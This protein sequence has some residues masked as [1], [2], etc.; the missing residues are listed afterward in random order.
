MAA[1]S[2]DDMQKEIIAGFSD[3][4]SRVRIA[5]AKAL[6]KFLERYRGSRGMPSGITVEYSVSPADFSS[7]PPANSSSDGIFGGVAKIL[8]DIAKN[9]VPAPTA[10]VEIEKEEEMKVE[11]D[12]EEEKRLR[13]TP[14]ENEADPAQDKQYQERGEAPPFVPSDAAPGERKSEA[15]SPFLPAPPAPAHSGYSIR[16]SATPQPVLRGMTR[17]PSFLPPGTISPDQGTAQFDLIGGE[18]AAPSQAAYPAVPS[19][20]GKDQWLEEFYQ[21]KSRPEWMTKTIEPLE[22]MLSAESLE[23][24]MAAAVA[25]VPLGKADLAVPALL[26]GAKAKPEF[27]CAAA[28]ILPWMVREKRAALFSDLRAVAGRDGD[29]ILLLD[30]L[31]EARDSRDEDLFWDVLDGER[32]SIDVA[33][34]VYNSLQEFYSIQRSNH[35]SGYVTFGDTSPD[36]QPNPETAKK[37]S[38]RTESGSDFQ[39]LVALALMCS[40]DREEAAK[41]AARI[42]DDS[43]LGEAL[44]RDAFQISLLLQSDAKARTV[45][46]VD[47]LKQNDPQRS[48]IALKVLVGGAESLRSLRERIDLAVPIPA[49][50]SESVGNGQPIIPRTPRGLKIDDVKPLVKDADPEIAAYAGYL[51]ALFE[52]PSGMPQLLRYWHKK[53]KENAS[54]SRLVYRAVAVLD[55]PKYLPVLRQIYGMTPEP[56]SKDFYWTIRIMSGP[57]ILKFRKEIRDRQ[58]TPGT[59]IMMPERASLSPIP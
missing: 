52:D 40:L 59:P 18:P 47:A 44:R 56:E 31:S 35:L 36:V 7:S 25:L 21:G 19:L 8:A 9:A 3:A 37:I 42:A 20:P 43:T 30:G 6:S 27:F 11:E 50:Q 24:R 16:S 34:Q 1:A 17:V 49:E 10:K 2:R 14:A 12:G 53:G 26:E 29:L 28:E 48:R 39:R 58:K 38:P 23:E 4:D 33:A 41:T 22:T 32:I 51:T 46:A 45:A 57:E 5:A 13:K 15:E 54:L 55:D